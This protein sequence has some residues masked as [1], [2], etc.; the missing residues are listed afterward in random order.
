MNIRKVLPV[1]T[2]ALVLSAVPSRSYTGSELPIGAKFP[3]LKP[4]GGWLH[5]VIFDHELCL[6]PISFLFRGGRVEVMRNSPAP[7][8]GR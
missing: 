7:T 4:I 8:D 2:L 6:G 1:V 5:K 3:T